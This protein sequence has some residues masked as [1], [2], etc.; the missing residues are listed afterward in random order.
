MFTD[1]GRAEYEKWRKWIEDENFDLSPNFVPTEDTP[2]GA[3]DYYKEME[4]MLINFDD[5]NFTW[6]TGC[7]MNL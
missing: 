1:E 7:G 2:Q 5:P 3:I 6:P 4:S